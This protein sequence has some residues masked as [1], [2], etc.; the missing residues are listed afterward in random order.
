MC[1]AP[2]V[3]NMMVQEARTRNFRLDRRVDVLT[4][5]AP[6]PSAVIAGMESAGFRITHVYG[7]TETYGP[8][9]VGP[10]DSSWDG[11]PLE[12]RARL[13]ARQGVRHQTL[14][15]LSVCHPETLEPVPSDG[16]T[17][18]EVMFRGNIVM[19]GY[20]DDPAA[21]ERAFAGGL[22]HSG[23]VAVITPDGSLQITDRSKDIII[24]G[25]ENIS[26]VEVESVL[27][28]HP[29]VLEAAV[30]A[31]PDALWGETPCAFV[32]LKV[33]A[34]AVSAEDVIAYCRGQLAHFKCPKTIVF[35]ELPKTSTGKVQ[36]FV[37]RE[38]ARALG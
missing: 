38:R 33:G 37:L 7:L 4:G 26:S 14:E 12:E 8:S 30:V 6:P 13:K 21:T 29:H 24:S 9:V 27:F 20:L 16:Q 10:W 31:R 2:T 1:G 35:S 11:L 19:K 23:D 17:A 5:G 25:G 15:H 28:R 34:P 22:F 3:L 18:G 32:T 36:K